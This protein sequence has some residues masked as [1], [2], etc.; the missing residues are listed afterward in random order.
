[1]VDNIGLSS[2]PLNTVYNNSGTVGPGEGDIL[3]ALEHGHTPT[4]RHVE[5]LRQD[6]PKHFPSLEFAF[7]PADITSQILN[8]GSPAPLDIQI[9]GRDRK[10]NRT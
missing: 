6:L 8:F 3:I 10:A 7:L 1:M 9:S 5:R 2:A 4:E